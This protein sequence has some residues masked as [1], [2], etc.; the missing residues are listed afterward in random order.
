MSRR[1]GDIYATT[2]FTSCEYD[3]LK[4]LSKDLRITFSGAVAFT[5]EHGLGPI[6]GANLFFK[7]WIEP[8]AWLAV[9]M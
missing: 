6:V 4:Q 3:V 7:E 9:N 1:N 2:K 5:F 8:S